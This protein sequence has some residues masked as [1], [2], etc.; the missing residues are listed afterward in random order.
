[1]K[2]VRWMRRTHLFRVDEYICSTCGDA[3][4]KPY[5][6]CFN[7]N[8]VM[9]KSKYDSSWA[10]EAEDMSSLLDDD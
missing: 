8:A 3:Y 9:G 10:N 7:C 1:M 2:R 4:D 6:T 5:S